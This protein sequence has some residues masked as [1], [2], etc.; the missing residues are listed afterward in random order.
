MFEEPLLRYEL[1]ST[2]KQTKNSESDASF[3]HTLTHTHRYA[4]KLIVLVNSGKLNRPFFGTPELAKNC[5][6]WLR[7]KLYFLSP[8]LRFLYF[9]FFS[10]S[11]RS[12]SRERKNKKKTPRAH[13]YVTAKLFL[14]VVCFTRTVQPRR[15]EGS[16]D[17]LTSKLFVA[18]SSTFLPLCHMPNST[19]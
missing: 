10:F 8:L 5:P 18:S 6:S 11:P 7:E 16:L 3:P 1:S 14:R 2:E 13:R 4:V 17:S 15:S 9:H 19:T 12:M